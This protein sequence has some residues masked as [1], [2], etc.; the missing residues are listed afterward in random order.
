MH[1]DK[2]GLI[3]ICIYLRSSAVPF[4]RARKR[5]NPATF[6][7]Q[8]FGLSFNLQAFPTITPMQGQDPEGPDQ[9]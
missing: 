8:G 3:S 6:G 2:D 5:K 7:S 9:A 1:T 4:C